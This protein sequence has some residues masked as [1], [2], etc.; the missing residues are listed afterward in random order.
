MRSKKT[1]GSIRW[2]WNLE[3]GYGCICRRNDSHYKGDPSCFQKEDGLFQVLEQL[4]NNLYRLNLTS[5]Y[6]VSAIFKVSNLS[7]F[8]VGK[9]LRQILLKRKGMMR[10]WLGNVLTLFKLQLVQLLI[11]KL[12][13]SK[14][15]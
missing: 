7:P 4:N 9:N 11:R 8:D 10:T 15:L 14:R 3:I 1:K 13:S 2:F 5:K 6:N 12:R